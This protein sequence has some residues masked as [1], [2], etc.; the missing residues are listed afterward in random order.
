MKW[1][2]IY[3]PLCCIPW[4][5]HKAI[6]TGFVDVFPVSVSPDLFCHH[7]Y[8]GTQ[9]KTNVTAHKRID[10]VYWFSWINILIFMNK[11][12]L[13]YFFF[14]QWSK[15]VCVK[16]MF[17]CFSFLAVS[18][19]IKKLCECVCTCMRMHILCGCVCVWTLMEW[20]SNINYVDM[21][22]SFTEIHSILCGFLFL[23]LYNNIRGHGTDGT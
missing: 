5:D 20:F 12:L 23:F 3:F 19:W 22:T 11:H 7:S 6:L 21:I 16:Y 18:R 2:C 17:F 10:L 1:K 4:V 8:C 9:L 15:Q 13:V 14:N